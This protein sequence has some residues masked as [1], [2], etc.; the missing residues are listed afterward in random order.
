ML[1]T[2]KAVAGQ[3]SIGPEFSSPVEALQSFIRLVR[4]QLPVLVFVTVLVSAI[5]AVY[6][7]TTPQSFTAQA[8]LII[9]TRRLQTLQQQPA[10]LDTPIDSSNVESQVELLKSENVALS[11]IKDLRLAESPEFSGSD[12]GL[13]GT[14]LSYVFALFGSS[15]PISEFER[16]RSIL[17]DF[18]KRLT[19]R[20]IGTS[21]VLEIRFRARNPDL[22]AQ[23]ANAV[24]DAYIV[25]QLEAKYQA[26]RRASVWLQDRLRELRQQASTAERAVVEF[27][28]KNKIIDAGGG[29]LINEQQLGELNSQLVV[30]RTQTADAQAK[31]DRIE[32]I[33]RADSPDASVNATVT[34]TLK[35]EVV[36]KLRTHY[37]ELASREAD[38]SAR[39]GHNHMAA[40]NLRN[41]MRETG[42][43]VLDEL[44]RLAET[45]KS[46]AAIARQR[47]DGIQTQLAQV[48]SQSQVTN[49]AQIALRD[50]ESSAQTYRALYDNFL[51]RHMESVQQQSFPSTEARLISAA[52]RPLAPS[53]PR[54]LLI[55]AITGFGGMLL[56]I[57][58]AIYRDLSERAFR[59]GMQVETTLLT[60]CIA[61]VPKFDRT[62]SDVRDRQNLPCG[63][64]DMPLS[65]F[66]EAIRSIKLAADVSAVG[67]ASKVIGF[68]SSL[69]NEGKSTLAANLA[70][71]IAHAGARTILVDA[72]LRNPWLSRVLARTAKAGSLDVISGKASL[73]KAVW[74]DPITNMAFLPMVSTSRLVRYSNEILGSDE[75]KKLFDELRRRYEWVVVD[76]SPLAPVVDVR[77]TTHLVDS[78]VLVIEWG[79]T[80]ID[81][82]EHA[83]HSAKVVYENLLGAV[84]NKVNVRQLRSYDRG[85]YYQN[86]HYARYGYTE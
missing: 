65:R 77:S 16:T 80:K 41:Q 51:Q 30:A 11:V 31:L 39:Y 18:E 67:K 46:E 27:K 2:N 54:T 86:K 20:R 73:D 52:S 58:F 47:E 66:T 19:V 55:F 85:N 61:M 76:F 57:S 64:V 62:K 82:V 25:D 81:T 34:D 49:E 71:L 5:G 33:L 3:G 44:R 1:Q 32:S 8:R 7:F 72:D 63:T 59:T 79:R 14:V 83:L 10:A 9:D 23:V 37:L 69:P 56:G 50:L 35:S 26:T 68:T 42:K 22:A 12:G 4:R 70:Q 21:Y 29:R 24:A 84:L 36:S 38:L 6:V 15:G 78:Y 17:G 53:H 43:A 75:M 60:N 40:V 45:Y 48:V 74:N 28:A 13:I